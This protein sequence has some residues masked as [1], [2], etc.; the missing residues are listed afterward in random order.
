VTVD[1]AAFARLESLAREPAAIERSV[2][3][4]TRQ[5]RLF[6]KKQD[7]ILICFPN[8]PGTIGEILDKA[9]REVGAIP[10]HWGEDQRWLTLIRTA[11]L[12][13]TTAVIGPPLVVLGLNKLSKITRTPLYI[14]HSI[15]TGYCSYEWMMHGIARGLD[16]K[17]WGYFN[18]NG[19]PLLCG[20]S[21]GEG[22][23]VHIRQEEYDIEIIDEEGNPLPDG[24]RG[25]ISIISKADPDL[26]V[27]IREH[28]A[29]DRSQCPCGR[30]SARL[31][32]F[33][34]DPNVDMELLRLGASLHTWDSVLDVR[35][36]RGEYG[37]EMEMVV[38]PGLELPKFPTCA[39]MEV[40][41]WDPERDKPFWFEPLW[42]NNNDFA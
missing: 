29:I 22:P 35:L 4:V 25:M 32:D 24:T 23:G 7:R 27:R 36:I 14:R 26:R 21:C 10:V 12:N 19:G 40:R 8:K 2:E 34:E 31:T 20:Q 28:A 18:I 6:A 37:L 41:N 9:V 13:K 17:T 42:R 38:F 11:F 1:T 16:C 5:L 39:K 15:T 30:S 33:E 3:Y